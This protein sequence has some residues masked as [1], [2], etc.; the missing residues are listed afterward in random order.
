M[1]FCRGE[2]SLNARRIQITRL[3]VDRV[4][5]CAIVILHMALAMHVT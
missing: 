3:V 2:C 4:V 1:A 5:F